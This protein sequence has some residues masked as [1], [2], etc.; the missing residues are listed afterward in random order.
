MS[1]SITIKLNKD[2]SIFAAGESTGF[3][4]RGGVQYYDRETGQ[5]EWTNYDAAVFAK[6]PGQ[7]EFYKSALVAGSIVEVSYQQQKIKSFDGQNGPV[8]SIE[9][10]D[11]KV[12]Y[13]GTVGQG[14]AP[15]QQQQGGYQQ[16]QQQ[17]PAAQPNQP[18]NNQGGYQH[19]QQGY[20]Q[21]QG[22]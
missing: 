10:I 5:K 8:L 4:I 22:K 13:I 16:P 21:Q 17:R 18:Q 19:P 20:G 6:A 12:G 7:V 9:L 11:A 1:G 15:Q 2:V 14:Q 3:G